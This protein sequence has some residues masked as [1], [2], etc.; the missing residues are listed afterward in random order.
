MKLMMSYYTM[1]VEAKRFWK[2]I[3]DSLGLY[4]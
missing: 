4:E 1:S 2:S 3:I